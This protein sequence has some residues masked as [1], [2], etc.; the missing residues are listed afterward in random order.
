M[1]LSSATRERLWARSNGQTSSASSGTSGPTASTGAGPS[2]GRNRRLSGNHY[3]IYTDKNGGY[4]RPA[5]DP[6]VA[7]N[8][9]VATTESLPPPGYNNIHHYQKVEG[10]GKKL[11]FFS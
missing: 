6:S 10:K 1:H 11:L 5:G 4:S 7:L 3:N 2:G 8:G 9:T